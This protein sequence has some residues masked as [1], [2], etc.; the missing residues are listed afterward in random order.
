VLLTN[1]LVH[2]RWRTGNLEES[3]HDY[4]SGW[5]GRDLAKLQPQY[6]VEKSRSGGG[7]NEVLSEIPV[8]RENFGC[9]WVRNEIFVVREAT[10][11]DTPSRAGGGIVGLCKTA[12]RAR[13]CPS[14]SCPLA[15]LEFI[16]EGPTCGGSPPKL[17]RMFSSLQQR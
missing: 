4:S 12:H 16:L 11:D 9:E 8:K 7:R 17:G 6:K 13:S 14:C 5:I 3:Q 2:K 1:R 10:R 15:L